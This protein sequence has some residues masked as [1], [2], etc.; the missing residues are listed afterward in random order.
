MEDLNKMDR[1]WLCSVVFMDI[2]QYSSQSV[3]L[4][5]KWKKRFNGYLAEAIEDVPES[6]R[7]ILDT[8]DGAAICFLGAPEV[9]MFAAL[10]LCRSFTVDEGEQQPGL[11]VRLGINL[12]PVKLVKDFNGALNAIGDGINAGQRIMSFAAEN[13]ILASQSYFEV[14]SRLSDDYKLLFRLKG[15]ETD[16]HVREHTVYYLMPPGSEKWGQTAASKPALGAGANPRARAPKGQWIP[17][18]IAGVAMTALAAVSVW[19]FYGSSAPPSPTANAPRGVQYQSGTPNPEPAAR[20]GGPVPAVSKSVGRDNAPTARETHAAGIAPVMNTP[21]ENTPVP[22]QAK[23]AARATSPE[24][25]AE[26]KAVRPRAPSGAPVSA[27]PSAPPST[28]AKAMYDDGMRL[29]EEG[30]AAEA[31][32]RF[33]DALRGKPDYTEAY[34]GR[35]EARRMLL[36]YDLSLE[37]CNKAIQLRADD[38]RGYN[39]RGLGRQMLRQLDEALPDFSEAIRLSPNFVI[40]Y[41]HRGTTYELLGQYD[42][43]LQDYSQAL[44]LAPRNPLFYIRRGGAYSNLKLYDKAIH[45][46]TEAIRLQPNNMNAY[47]VRALAEEAS[48]DSAGAA[49]DRGHMKGLPKRKIK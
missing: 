17:W 45:D 42:H 24:P 28:E 26:V 8:G 19:H 33:D 11:R 9:A 18:L 3:D 1:T 5:M 37:D 35:A 13:Q 40:A 32:R 7:V 25:N 2:A 14:V 27:P 39:C 16:K 10:K 43:A 49:A 29:I 41:E 47:R 44:R 34:V 21:A 38:A 20:T 48:G 12:G 46:Y 15:I 30:K 23:P 36:Q 4:Q 22:A 6:D 31:A